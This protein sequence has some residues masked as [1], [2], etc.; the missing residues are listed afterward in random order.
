LNGDFDCAREAFQKA[1][2][3]VGPGS[4]AP[5]G[6]AQVIAF[7]TDLWDSIV[8]YEALAA[9]VEEAGDDEAADSALEALDEAKT[10]DAEVTA[11]RSAITSDAGGPPYDIPMVVN[12][13]VLRALAVF[14]ND[15]HPI[16]ER[17]L[18]RSGRYLPMI[19]RIFA[20]EGIP[21]DLANMALV[22]SSFMPRAVSS[23]RA[24]GLWQFMSRTGRQYGLTTNSLV[25]ERSDPEKAT[26]AAA[27]YLSFLHD[28]FNDWYLAMAAY[29]AGE[30]KILR[31]LAKT[32]SKDFW[33]LAKTRAIKPQTQSY[34][35][36]VLAA[37]LINRNPEHYGFDVEYEPALLYETV[38]VDRP[39][40]LVALSRAAQVPLDDLQSLNPELKRS[41]T[42]RQ[43]EGYSLK[44]PPG[45]R[46]TVVSALDSVPTARIPD[47]KRYVVRRGDTLSGIARRHRVPEDELA[48]FNGLS[49]DATL[50]RGRV[51]E[52]PSHSA[53]IRAKKTKGPTR[54]ARTAS[55]ASPSPKTYRVK[56]G[57]TLYAIARRHG[58][59]VGDISAA[60]SL[61][62]DA[63][64]RPGD[65]LTIP[66][67]SR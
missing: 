43:P 45:W 42:P 47:G 22:E 3:A 48:A 52:I 1:L 35:P 5:S 26:R 49:L 62:P 24:H 16:I 23:A 60:N 37:T 11:A 53:P 9:P 17:G 59:T 40:S 29:N 41:V 4:G 46:E 31:A 55:S 14:Q 28:V 44:V 63:T 7:S 51:L 27:K 54:T 20:E 13:S 8:R 34:V 39:V 38:L 58:T 67:S 18:S 66:P 32:G 19:H 21:R 2:D 10:S 12:E 57:D 61:S 64:I 30:G 50:R 65:R 36:A 15:L 56:S 25:D 6:D 33:Q